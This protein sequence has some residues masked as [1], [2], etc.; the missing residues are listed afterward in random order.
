MELVDNPMGGRH[1][2]GASKRRS[3]SAVMA[4]PTAAE[5]A[6]SVLQRQ[7]AT[8]FACTFLARIGFTG[9]TLARY[10]ALL[11][12]HGAGITDLPLLG[13]KGLQQL[14]FESPIDRTR[15]L[16]ATVDK[17]IR[18]DS[19]K[20]EGGGPVQVHV[21][22]GIAL[23]SS[24]N[25]VDQTCAIKLFI[26]LY[27]ID[28]SMIGADPG[29]IPSYVWR[30]DGYIS[31]AIGG[32]EKS[33]THELILSQPARGLLLCPLEF[34]CT[35]S[36]PMDLRAFPFDSDAVE[37]NF[38]QSED[39][40]AE[41]WEIVPDHE[42]GVAVSTKC[43]F[44][45][46]SL[47]EFELK[48]FSI[49]TYNR[50]GGNGVP[51]ARCRLHLHLVREPDYYLWKI[52]MPIFLTT[53]ICFSS[54]LFANTALADRINTSATMFLT[55]MALLFVVSTDLPKTTFLTK[56]DVY[57]NTS[58]MVQLGVLFESCVVSGALSSGGADS[59]AENDDVYIAIDDWSLRI[60]AVGYLLFTAVYFVPRYLGYRRV[61]ANADDSPITPAR[62]DKS[63]GE[64]AFHKFEKGSNVFF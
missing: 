1:P 36:N 15:I 32:G 37:L 16:D 55:T 46:D 56:I 11:R 48:G 50:M 60:G 25:T 27:W 49:E 30:P 20:G 3:T 14:G 38:L 61:A 5:Q 4:P 29:H 7:G 12:E 39:S 51:Y 22:F 19:P 8:E 42:G 10:C 59:T 24:I 9:A 35:L 33:R 44:D 41:E 43:F 53:T 28:P 58:M 31:N 17:V 57:L 45:I 13:F 34:E 26:D 18:A 54:M 64:L 21:K 63:K 47:G 6:A 2:S 52:V 23:L 40:S 62:Y